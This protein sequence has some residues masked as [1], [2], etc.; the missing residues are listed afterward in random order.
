MLNWK[1]ASKGDQKRL[2]AISTLLT[3]YP[4]L[5]DQIFNS[6]EP[7]LKNSPQALLRGRSS[8]EKVLIGI[9]LDIWNESAGV[10]INDLGCLDSEN[11][12]NVF[13]AFNSL[14]TPTP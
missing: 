9:A 8:G 5:L 12:Q 2:T 11:L 4:R 13:S 7:S 14:R 3:R 10:K 6:F 1:N